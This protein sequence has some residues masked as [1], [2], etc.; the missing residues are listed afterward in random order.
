MDWQSLQNFNIPGFIVII[1]IVFVLR[2]FLD[3]LVTKKKRGGRVKTINIP[4]STE[5]PTAT[6][7]KVP[8]IKIIFLCLAAT[9]Y[10]ILLYWGSGVFVILNKYI[11]LS[12]FLT[13]SGPTLERN[14]EYAKL[15]I[16]VLLALLSLSIL[17]SVL[18]KVFTVG[19]QLGERVSKKWRK[20]QTPVNRGLV[21]ENF[22]TSTKR[23][24]TFVNDGEKEPLLWFLETNK[25]PAQWLRSYQGRKFSVLMLRILVFTILT[26]IFFVLPLRNQYILKLYGLFGGKTIPAIGSYG[27]GVIIAVIILF[28]AGF[29]GGTLLSVY[30]VDPIFNRINRKERRQLILSQIA[31]EQIA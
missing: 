11:S 21:E 20:H 23:V 22:S 9:L 8:W 28:A 17:N 15:F 26:L 29:L 30:I 2:F 1:F 5:P 7:R 18:I 6:K 4:Q 24:E 25:I 14:L 19:E 27:T 10:G 3:L 31:K 13:S 12:G 16:W